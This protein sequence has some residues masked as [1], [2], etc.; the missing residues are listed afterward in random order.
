MSKGAIRAFAGGIIVSTAVIA[1]Y[2]YLYQ[3]KDK[4]TMDLSQAKNML[5]QEGFQVTKETSAEKSEDPDKQVD[6]E[7]V[8]KEQANVDDTVKTEKN[9]DKNAGIQD[10][11]NSDKE[12]AATYTLTIQPGMTSREIAELLVKEGILKDAS[13]F[14]QYME[15]NDLSK[16]IQIGEY[17]LTNNMTFQQV[18]KTISK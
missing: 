2:Y 13:L 1:G 6:P 15:Q 17:V 4:V 5:E 3:P 7:S 8:K 10:S 14:Q 9:M 11:P 16:H 12:P 18:A